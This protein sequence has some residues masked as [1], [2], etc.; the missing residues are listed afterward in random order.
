MA[1]G[2]EP[3]PTPTASATRRLTPWVVSVAL[4][5]ALVVGAA[6]IVWQVVEGPEDPPASA[7]SFDAPSY[8]PTLIPDREIETEDTEAAEAAAIEALL[9]PDPALDTF[10]LDD[11]TGDAPEI[12][13][14]SMPVTAPDALTI[15]RP[16]NLGATFAGL[17]AGDARDVVYVVDGSG[18]MLTTL[19]DVMDR[20]RQSIDGLHPTQRFQVIVFQTVTTDDETTTTFT[21]PPA[22]SGKL[23]L[24]PASSD[25]KAEIDTWLTKTVRP[26]GRSNPAAALEAAL[27]LKPDAI[28]LLSS[29]ITDREGGS[30]DGAELLAW[31]DGANPID[32]ESGRR[33]VLIQTVQVLDED[34]EELLRR[35]AAAHGGA[36]GY[37]YISREELTRAKADR[38]EPATAAPEGADNT[39]PPDEQR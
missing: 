7:I 37:N 23:G 3:N 13:P 36:N 34:P 12:D 25:I 18:S 4:H 29:R 22:R 33:R 16:A 35:I 30:F 39:Q 1:A 28:F 19:P 24:L 2:T 20:L 17:A 5:A 32:K 21:T 9:A 27:D 31:L 10:E 14:L 8:N 38:A 15:E 11:L 26:R 6:F